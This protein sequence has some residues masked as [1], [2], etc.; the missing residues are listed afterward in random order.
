M[1]FRLKPIA[2]LVVILIALIQGC[3]G[4]QIKLGRAVE[5]A[6]GLS[7]TYLANVEGEPGKMGDIIEFDV[8]QKFGNTVLV[9]TYGM[10]DYRFRSLIKEPAFESDYMVALNQLAQGDSVSI[11]VELSTIPEDQ[12]PPQ[13][14]GKNGALEFTIS[15]RGVWNEEK[16]ITEMI[17]RL[18]NGKPE[19]W[20]TT[21]RGVRVF[22]DDRG[23]GER[24]DIG[25]TIKMHVK[26]LFTN[27]VPF[28]STLDDEPIQFVFGVDPIEPKAWEDVASLMAEGDKIT[29][30]A[31]YQMAYGD[32]D[33]RPI[34]KYSTLVF[35]I[36][37]LNIQ[38]PY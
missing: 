6:P 19:D 34:L 14:A 4:D 8:I 17:D 7:M 29:L 38:K 30:I 20:Q 11:E 24:A 9:N 5:L 31:P 36:D 13:L 23:A 27:G 35:E 1:I 15:V 28:M 18:S 26:G 2:G 3:S 12:R 37:V 32:R 16:L 33:R 22:W 25:D 10:P 21:S